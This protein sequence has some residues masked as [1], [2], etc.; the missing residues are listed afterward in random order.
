VVVVV[1]VIAVLLVLLLGLLVLVVMVLLAVLLLDAAAGADINA[2]TVTAMCAAGL[3]R[4]RGCAPA[5]AHLV[6]PLLPLR[7]IIPQVNSL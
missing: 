7:L 4:R 3:L 5:E 6:E 1:V 2:A